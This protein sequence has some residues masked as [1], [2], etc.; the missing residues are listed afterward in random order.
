MEPESDEFDEYEVSETDNIHKVAHKTGMS[1]R[2]IYSLNTDLPI[3]EPISPGTK[4]KVYQ[5]HD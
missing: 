4:I 2:Q 5:M 1:V 3:F